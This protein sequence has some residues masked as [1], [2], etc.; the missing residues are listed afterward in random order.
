MQ[1]NSTSYVVEVMSENIIFLE[2]ASRD[3]ESASLTP[4][5]MKNLARRQQIFI[6]WI[7]Q[8]KIFPFEFDSL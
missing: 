6:F 3:V 4:P 7:F 8:V 2:V 5:N 1:Q